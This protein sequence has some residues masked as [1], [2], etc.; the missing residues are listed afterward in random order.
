MFHPCRSIDYFCGHTQ[1]HRHTDTHKHTHTYRER[2]RDRKKNRQK[3]T[4]ILVRQP[5]DLKYKTKCTSYRF[6][7]ANYL[8]FP[9][10]S[11]AFWNDYLIC[12]KHVVPPD[13]APRLYFSEKLVFLPYSYQVNYYERHL[14]KF[15]ATRRKQEQKASSL[16]RD[17]VFAAETSSSISTN[18]NSTRGITVGEEM[19]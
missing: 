18:R 12:D 17:A 4:R 5:H 1:T 10:T 13:H 2:E 19:L 7:Q 9:G 11:G 3:Q 16:S 6:P 14:V 8:I 15:E